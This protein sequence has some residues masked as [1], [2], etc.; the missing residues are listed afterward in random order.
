MC[1][2]SSFHSLIILLAFIVSFTFACEQKKKVSE[3]SE[4]EIKIGE[5]LVL[6]ARCN[7]CHTPNLGEYN[8]ENKKLLSGHPSSSK[9]PEIP[10]VPI[11]SQQWMEFVS[12]LE[13]TVWIDRN[14]IVFSA[15]ITPDKETGIGNWDVD[16]FI[17]TI[18]TGKHPGWRKDLKKP[19]P[20]LEY[21]TLS[22]DKLTAIFA[23][24]TSIPPVKN[25]CRP[26]GRTWP[27]R[28]TNPACP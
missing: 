22:N 15:N 19:M 6:E 26:G 13:S 25:S 16:T 20:W 4:E 27:G 10:K 7:F 14:T 12:N 21:A 18:R 17:T 9:I 11:G 28:S 23:Y 24:L 1:F 3:F 5:T 2:H 8:S